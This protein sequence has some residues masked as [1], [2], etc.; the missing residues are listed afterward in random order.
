MQVAYH[1]CGSGA[2]LQKKLKL[3]A[4]QANAGVIMIGGAGTSLGVIPCTTTSFAN[5]H[6]LA[7]DEGVYSTTQGDAE[8][9]VTVDVRPDLVIRARMS[10]GATEGTSL[11]T[12]VNTAASA[13]GTVITDADV[14]SA[15][16]DGGTIWCTKGNN[17]GYS[18][19]VTAFSSATSAT[20]TVPFP[21]AIAVGDEFIV[22]P[23]NMHGTGAAGA[24]GSG[25]LQTTTLFTEA[26]STIAC[27]TGGEVS[28]VEVD[29]KGATNSYVYFALRDHVHNSAA[30][31]S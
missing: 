18:R 31:V 10:G 2:S 24:D 27:G 17:V 5:A 23:H 14:G 28:V 25:F 1:L 7:I 9:L 12:L 20:V 21:R 11:V 15:D 29:L 13:G 22:V 19:L 8:G 30:L 4:A 3:G 26:D 16:L 6:G